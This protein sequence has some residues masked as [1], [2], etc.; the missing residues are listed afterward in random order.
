[1]AETAGLRADAVGCADDAS[2][3][4]LTVGTIVLIAEL[5][6]A[7]LPNRTG[8]VFDSEKA[9]DEGNCAGANGLGFLTAF[10]DVALVDDSTV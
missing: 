9:G 8:D 2:G 3:F 5:D 6:N 4:H 1:M 10:E 7:E